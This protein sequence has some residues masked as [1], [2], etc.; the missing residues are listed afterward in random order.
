MLHSL[1]SELPRFFGPYNLLFLAQAIGVTIALTIVGCG[2]G[3]NFGFA[4][5]LLR[6][7]RIIDI[8]PLR[9]SAIGFV[10]LVRRLPFL[11]LLFLV[12]FGFQAGGYTL[13]GMAVACIT[14][15]LRAAAIASETVRAGL[16]SVHPNQWDAAATMNLS[17]L[18]QLRHVVLPQAW[19]VILP[20]AMIQFI[21][22]LKATSIASQISVIELTYAGKIMNQ[23]G[24]SATLSYGTVLILYYVL[25]LAV[26]RV[27]RRMEKRLVLPQHH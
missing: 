8:P 3:Y 1:L 10:E 18:D 15:I 19:R 6:V 12:M 4:L 16:E 9:W 23:K 27:V 5:A 2:I 20:P 21:Q 25:C 17:R 26:E 22:L 7:Q 13:T 14:I 11:V 24:F